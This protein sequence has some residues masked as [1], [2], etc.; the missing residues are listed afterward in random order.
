FDDQNRVELQL[1]TVGGE[2]RLD[3][4]FVPDSYQDRFE[5]DLFDHHRDGLQQESDRI[6]AEAQAA[7]AKTENDITVVGHSD[8]ADSDPLKHHLDVRVDGETFT[9]IATFN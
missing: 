2:V 1:K 4:H 9:V 5:V 8:F 3:P 6:S 7:K